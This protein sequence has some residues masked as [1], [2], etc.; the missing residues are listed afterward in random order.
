[1]IFRKLLFRL[2]KFARMNDTPSSVRL[3]RKL[4]VEHFVKHQVIEDVP[5]NARRIKTSVDG[6]GSVPGIIV[7]EDGA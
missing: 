7:P 1:M 5:G 4:R 6:D 2:A 3:N